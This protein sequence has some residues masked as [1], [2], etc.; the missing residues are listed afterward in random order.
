MKAHLIKLTNEGAGLDPKEG[1]T[2][3][4]IRDTISPYTASE[5]QYKEKVAHAFYTATKDLWS[6]DDNAIHQRELQ[7]RPN[8]NDDAT[9]ARIKQD[10][11]SALRERVEELQKLRLADPAASVEKDTQVQ[12]ALT[13]FDKKDFALSTVRLA[14][15]RI[16]AQIAAKIPSENMSPITK[17][18]A[19][20]DFKSLHVLALPGNQNQLKQ[21]VQALYNNYVALYR[22][23]A[24]HALRYA[25]RA[26]RNEAALAEKLGGIMK[27]M[28]RGGHPDQEEWAKTDAELEIMKANRVIAAT[29]S[30]DEMGM[31][32]IGTA[33][34][35]DDSGMPT[36]TVPA[37]PK[38]PVA[39]AS[40]HVLDYGVKVGTNK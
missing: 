5:F 36:G 2:F 37:A 6:L 15:A 12:S 10:V 26:Q 17:D 13:N 20:S 9:T 34:V 8:Q 31:P 38:K 24:P 30:Y 32:T 4:R 3:E 35:Y 33:S 29:P 39:R 27:T 40:K 22:E 1:L 19:L 18:Q 23:Y 14:D 21:E 11:S 25:I 28:F 7:W 16:A